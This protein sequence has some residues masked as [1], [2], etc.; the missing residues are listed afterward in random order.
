MKNRQAFELTYKALGTYRTI[1]I[2]ARHEE[3][4][5][6]LDTLITDYLY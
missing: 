1:S 3:K 6:F 4:K 2:D 5:E